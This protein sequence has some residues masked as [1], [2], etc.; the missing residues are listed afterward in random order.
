[1]IKVTTKDFGETWL[2]ASYIVAVFE[3][4]GGTCI[5]M[6]RANDVLRV[7]ESVEEVMI[8]IRTISCVLRGA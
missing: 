6:H 8:S 4:E 3:D 1:M 7:A 2:N 5:T